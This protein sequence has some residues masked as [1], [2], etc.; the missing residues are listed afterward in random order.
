MFGLKKQDYQDAAVRQRLD[1]PKHASFVRVAT[2]AARLEAMCDAASA[3]R[4]GAIAIY[5]ERVADA[6][7]I[8]SGLARAHGA[9][10]VGLL[11]GTL[12]GRERVDLVNGAVWSRFDPDRKRGEPARSVYLVMTSAGEVGL[13]LDADHAVVDLTTLGSMIQRVGRVNRTGSG[14]ATVTV[15]YTV[16]ESAPA[17]PLATTH[18]GRLRAARSKTLEVLRSVPDLSPGALH[19]VDRAAFAASTVSR[20]TFPRLDPVVVEGFAAT[21][22]PIPRPA[23]GIY[24]RGVSEDPEIPETWI[25]WRWDVADLVRCGVKTAQVVV[26]F[27]RP[28]AEELARVPEKYAVELVERA[29]VRAG[30]RG[31]PVVVVGRAGEVFAAQLRDAAELPSVAYATVLLPPEAGGLLGSGLPDVD[32][33]DMVEDVGD[34]DDRVRYVVS[35]GGSQAKA[36]ERHP[37]WADDAVELRI[38]VPAPE[39]GAK[40]RECVYALRRPDPDLVL[41]AGEVTRYGRT[42]QTVEEHGRRVGKASRCIGEALG[43]P[44]PLVDALA[45]A[46]TWHDT[47]KSRRLWQLAAGIAPGGPPLA[48]TRRGRFRPEWLAGYR[49]EFGSVADAERALAQD[50]SHRDLILHLIA[51]HHG[52][53][54]PGFARP[55]QWDPESSPAANRALAERIAERYARLGAQYGPW[56]LAWFESLLKCA[57]AWVSSGRDAP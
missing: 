53:A 49:H 9:E 32:A 1:A 4:T 6:R 14:V 45:L 30:G 56:R 12:R 48:K 38:A 8:A 19:R 28:R 13:D 34:S 26:S 15:V 18:A 39:A 47:G 35:P 31:L 5:A 24:L 22:V 2:P 44:P 40:E 21:S 29:L 50:T 37:A 43:L 51:A 46:G 33:Q 16:S 52:W 55:E 27:F 20:V 17:E 41:G 57:D 10:R 11:T 42:D 3:H 7:R 25:A 54:R 36:G 23:V